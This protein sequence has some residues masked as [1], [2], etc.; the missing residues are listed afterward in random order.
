MCA[1]V[2]NALPFASKRVVLDT[3]TNQLRTPRPRIEKE[4]CKCN[5][6]TL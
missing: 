1:R 4:T 6:N 2:Q 3:R 5:I